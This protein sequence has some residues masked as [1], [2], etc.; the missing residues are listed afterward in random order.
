[1]KILAFA[2]DK[3][4]TCLFSIFKSTKSSLNKYLKFNLISNI[5]MK[6]YK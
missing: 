1:M 6:L 3:T 5:R 2:K 4:S